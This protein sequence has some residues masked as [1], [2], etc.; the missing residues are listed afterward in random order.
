MSEDYFN[1]Y[2]DQL[3]EG[4]IEY[5]DETFPPS[6]LDVNE[7]DLSFTSPVML[8]GQAYLAEDTLILNLNIQTVATISCL[9]CNEP[10]QLKIEIDNFYHAVPLQEIKSGVYNL[11]ELL[12]ETILVETPLLAECHNGKCPQRQELKKYFKKE[13][14]LTLKNGEEGHNPFADLR[15]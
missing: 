11:R 13:N 9:V 15:F 10:V 8:K 3:K 14:P 1:I 5:L 4:G 7:R 2:S 6:F 12:R